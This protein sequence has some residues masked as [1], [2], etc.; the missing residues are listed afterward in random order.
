MTQFGLDPLFSDD[1]TLLERLNNNEISYADIPEVTDMVQWI[2]D[3]ADKGWLGSDH[4]DKGRSDISPAM[5]S[6]EAVMTF[7]RNT[8]FYTDFD[9]GNK[10]SVD[11]FALMPVFPPRA[12][13]KGRRA[14]FAPKW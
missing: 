2:A 9:K 8:W 3:A 11:D 1:P 10:Y 7:I 14:T 13:L 12:V 6:G 4:L 5:S